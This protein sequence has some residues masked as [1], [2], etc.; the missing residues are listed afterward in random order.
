MSG[1]E[2]RPS[3]HARVQIESIRAPVRR[4]Q[5]EPAAVERDHA[6]MHID[7]LLYP[8]F[9]ELDAL[10]PWEILSSLAAHRPDDFSAAMVTLDGEEPVTASQARSFSLTARSLSARTCLWCPAAA[11]AP[12]A[13][14]V[15]HGP[16]WRKG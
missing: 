3:I 13:R 6:A 16:P 1:V 8:G 2:S 7:V 5:V 15:G 12:A 11:G 10:A 4:E 14:A 9:D